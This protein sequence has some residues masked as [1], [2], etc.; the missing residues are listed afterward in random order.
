ME[1]V[2]RDDLNRVRESLSFVRESMNREFMFLCER[3]RDIVCVFL[4]FFFS[5][6]FSLRRF[7]TKYLKVPSTLQLTTARVMGKVNVRRDFF[8]FQ[9]CALGLFSGCPFSPHRGGR[10]KYALGS[11]H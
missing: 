7:Q 11:C 8:L 1:G 4:F 9:R 6:S 5:V 2:N 10:L 3:E